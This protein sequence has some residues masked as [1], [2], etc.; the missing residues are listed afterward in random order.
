MNADTDVLVFD[1]TMMYVMFERVLRAEREGRRASR[2]E[3]LGG[4]DAETDERRAKNVLKAAFR[5][6][7]GAL[8]H[9]LRLYCETTDAMEV[10][11]HA[12]KVD[13]QVSVQITETPAKAA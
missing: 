10:T 5:K 7:P 2:A 12:R 9:I 11:A 4:L 3:L 8:R 1:D 6:D 13:G